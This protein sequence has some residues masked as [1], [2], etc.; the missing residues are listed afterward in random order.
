MHIGE[1]SNNLPPSKIC[2]DEHGPKGRQSH[3]IWSFSELPWV[4]TIEEVSE[5]LKSSLIS[6]TTMHGDDALAHQIDYYQKQ[7][8]P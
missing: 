4:E 1:N 7:R 3:E 6:A 5:L 8:Y 2:L